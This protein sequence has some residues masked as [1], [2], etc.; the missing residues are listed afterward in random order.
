MDIGISS[1]CFY[2]HVKT[3]ESIALMKKIGFN[4]G[5]IFLNST[6]EYEIDFGKILLEEKLKHD[7]RINS[8]HSFSSSFE[9]YLFDEYKRRRNDSFIL[10]EKIC[11]LAEMLGAKCYTFHGM[12]YRDIKDVDMKF[13]TDVYNKL[14]YTAQEHGIKLCQ[15]NVFW[16]MS[17]NVDF[18][19]EI[20]DRCKGSL[21]FTLDIKQAY[22][23]G[24]LPED[25]IDVMGSSI[26]NFHINDKD[27]NNTCLMPGKGNVDY[28]KISC[29][30][31]EIR[32]NG[33][34]IVEVYRENFNEYCE[35]IES[36]RY[37]E[38][39]F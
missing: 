20:K 6:S 3:E 18:L 13:I 17:N 28:K 39:Q 23:A 10:F 1:A 35:L 2:P 4:V 32:Y 16:C 12:K 8:V 14:T 9:P 27:N 11:K 15:E 36:K 5:E 29:K 33:V 34:G 31:K 19:Q 25:Y 21:Y 26:A 30:F 24:K 7:F 22:K 37:I 38:K